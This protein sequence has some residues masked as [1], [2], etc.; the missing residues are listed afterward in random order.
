[1]Y[2]AGFSQSQEAYEEA[3]ND[4]FKTLDSLE[5]HL[6]GKSYCIGDSLTES[7]IRLF[8]TLV[9]FDIAYFSLFKTNKKQISDY[10]NL[11]RYLQALLAIPSFSKHTNI[12]HIKTG[13]YSVKALNPSGIVPSGPE[14]NWFSLLKEETQKPPIEARGD[15]E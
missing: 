10:P 11:S 13:Y 14:L 5:K 9:R 3:F 8:V 2:R 12:S 7:D 1:M 15:V 6:D 4:I